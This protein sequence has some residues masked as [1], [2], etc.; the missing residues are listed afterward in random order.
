MKNLSAFAAET[1]RGTRAW[2]ND[3]LDARWNHDPF[4]KEPLASADEYRRLFESTRDK[5][6]PQVDAIEER[7]GFSLDKAWL[8]ELALH[9]QIVKKKSELAYPHGRLL[10][11]LL[12]SYIEK[13]G[14]Q[15]VQVLETG[16]ARGFS[17]LCMARAI[18]DSGATGR[19]VTL[20][21]L[22]HLT[23]QIWN[24]I[25]DHDGR[26]SRAELLRPWEDLTRMILFLQ[27]DTLSLLGKIGIDRVNFAFLDAQHLRSSVLHEFGTVAARQSAGDVV[28]FDDVTAASYPGVVEAV[29]EIEGQGEYEVERLT[30]TA[31]RAY[32]WATRR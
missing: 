19:I 2:I 28:F 9:T 31:E 12:R 23:P 16:T 26:K 6:F 20:D 13:S 21:V 32:A 22:P 10:Y 25:D 1:I 11:A 29:A 30:L 3:R 5:A 7:L 27:G 14:T 4:G 24:C 8:D 15:F 17:A 18:R